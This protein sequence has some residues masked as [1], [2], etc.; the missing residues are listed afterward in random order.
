[1]PILG[2]RGMQRAS[3][4]SDQ[5]I[6]ARHK[7]QSGFLKRYKGMFLYMRNRMVVQSSL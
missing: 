2:A 1:M 7:K 6:K 3:L 4:F 5:D